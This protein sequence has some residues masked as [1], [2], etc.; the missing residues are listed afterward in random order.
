MPRLL[1]RILMACFLESILLNSFLHVIIVVL[2]VIFD[3]TIFNLTLKTL[4]LLM[5]NDS[6]V[7]SHLMR[8]S[9]QMKEVNEKLASC[10][11]DNS[12]GC[13]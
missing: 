7:M 11:H 1:K 6:S 13:S 10:S 5:L 8:L 9:R 2:S 3:L 12:K 4:C